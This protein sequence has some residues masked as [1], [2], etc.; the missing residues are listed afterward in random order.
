VSGVRSQK[1][2]VRSQKSEVRSQ[3]SEVRSHEE[4]WI[5]NWEINYL[6]SKLPNPK[7]WQWVR[8]PSLSDPRVSVLD[9]LALYVVLGIT[10]LEFNRSP[11][12]QASRRIKMSTCD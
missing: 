4:A 12:Q 1:S 11:S 9:I 10:V 5:G 7:S 2:E 3:K 8:T 6:K